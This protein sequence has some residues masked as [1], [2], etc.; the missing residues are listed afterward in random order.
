MGWIAS[1]ID[2]PSAP[3]PIISV[4]LSK[5]DSIVFSINDFIAIRSSIFS[6]ITEITEG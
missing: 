3:K 6:I 1:A 5:G 4:G 2:S